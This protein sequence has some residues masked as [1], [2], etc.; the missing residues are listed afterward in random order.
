[1]N[2]ASEFNELYYLTIDGGAV[3]QPN[4]HLL[5][6]NTREEKRNVYPR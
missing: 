1:M 5:F 2:T 4:G 6:F 3:T